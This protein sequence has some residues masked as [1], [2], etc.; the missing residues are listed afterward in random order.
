MNVDGVEPPPAPPVVEPLRRRATKVTFTASAEF[1]EKLDRLAALMRP[2]VLRW[3]FSGGPRCRRHGELERLEA[4]RFAET[5]TPRKSLEETDTSASSRYI[6]AAVRRVVRKR[7]RV[8]ARSWIDRDDAARRVEVW[9][10]TTT[11]PLAAAAT[12]VQR[13]SD[14]Y[15]RTMPISPSG[16][17]AKKSWISIGGTAVVCPSPR[18]S[19]V[20]A[21]IPWFS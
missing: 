7:D 12:A 19:M 11:T 10:S 4:K 15:V 2:S 16:I 17:T 20:P 5:R 6:P 21:T 14:F 18:L 1:R 13:M 8:D 3:R 9:S